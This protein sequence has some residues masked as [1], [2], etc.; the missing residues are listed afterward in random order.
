[1]EI[2][3]KKTESGDKLRYLAIELK[4]GTIIATETPCG[5]LLEVERTQD[6]FTITIGER[7]LYVED[8]FVGP[9]ALKGEGLSWKCTTP[10]DQDGFED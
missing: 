10:E 5:R 8:G 3:S 4:Q 1:M 7:I 9:K 6:T 2:E